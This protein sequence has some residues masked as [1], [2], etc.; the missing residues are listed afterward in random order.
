M[1][2]IADKEIHAGNGLIQKITSSANGISD[3]IIGDWIKNSSEKLKEVAPKA[4]S[5]GT[6]LGF[7]TVIGGIFKK[8]KNRLKETEDAAQ[9][10]DDGNSKKQQQKRTV[11]SHISKIFH[12]VINDSKTVS[13]EID[14]SLVG[15]YKKDVSNADKDAKSEKQIAAKELAKLRADYMNGSVS[16]SDYLSKVKEFEA[17]YGEINA[18]AS[19]KKAKSRSKA[20]EQTAALKEYKTRYAEI[21]NMIKQKQV[22]PSIGQAY[23]TYI[24]KQQ[25]L[26]NDGKLEFSDYMINLKMNTI[27]N[28][29]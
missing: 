7:N 3:S 20:M 2:E 23:L 29:A 13:S 25:K 6:A 18:Q 27:K 17:K 11:L 19:T 21:N 5:I 22:E 8:H 15:K 9:S 28:K 10:S 24:Q 14:K 1:D 26:Y 4:I 12:S 16:E